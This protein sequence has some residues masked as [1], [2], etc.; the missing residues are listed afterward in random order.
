MAKLWRYPY[1]VFYFSSALRHPDLCHSVLRCIHKSRLASF[2]AISPPCIPLGL[3]RADTLTEG[4]KP[5]E[6][7][8]QLS[9]RSGQQGK[10]VRAPQ[11]E[12]LP[13]G[14]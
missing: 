13:S 9:N 5:L 4:K 10:P 3:C 6:S 11:V 8:R 12:G 14:G 1:V 7:M 2:Q